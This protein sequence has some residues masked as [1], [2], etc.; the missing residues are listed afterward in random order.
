MSKWCGAVVLAVAL[1]SSGGVTTSAQR[2]IPTPAS[3]IG[4]PACADQQLASFEQAVDYLQQLSAAM[5]RMK[6]IEL[7]KTAEGRP[8]V[9]AIIGR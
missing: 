9:L 6:L 1:A 5:P 3:V 2:A 4:F 7:G 8:H